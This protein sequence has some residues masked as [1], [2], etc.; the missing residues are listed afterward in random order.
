VR[1][2]GEHRPGGV[3]VE[4]PGGEVRQRLVFEVTDREFDDGV[5]ALL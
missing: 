4:V 5:L 2:A 3:G 1:K